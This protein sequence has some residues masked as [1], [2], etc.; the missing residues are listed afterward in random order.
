MPWATSC[1]W[2]AGRI[3]EGTLAAQDTPARF[4]GDEFAVLLEDLAD[5]RRHLRSPSG[6]S[7]RSSSR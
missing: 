4:G 2:I 7:A 5:E 3:D 6:Y 1:S